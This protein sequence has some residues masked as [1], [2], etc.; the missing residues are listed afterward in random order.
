MGKTFDKAINDWSEKNNTVNKIKTGVNLH[1][2]LFTV[3][4]DDTRL[5]AY[6]GWFPFF[7]N[8]GIVGSLAVCTKRP[9][10]VED[11]AVMTWDQ[12]H[13]MADAGWEIMSHSVNHIAFQ[14]LTEEEARYEFAESKRVLQSHGFNPIN[15]GWCVSEEVGY[16]NER[17]CREYY[18]SARGYYNPVVNKDAV[19]EI[20]FNPYN[21][22]SAGERVDITTVEGMAWIKAQVD[23]AY[24]ENRWLIWTGHS[25]WA[26][27]E[28]AMLELIQYVQSKNIQIVTINEGLDL[29][30]NY[31]DA[32]NKFSVGEYGVRID[33][34]DGHALVARYRR[35]G[36]GIRASEGNREANNTFLGYLSGNTSVGTSNTH[37][38]SESGYLSKL[39]NSVAVGFKAMKET[40]SGYY[41]IAIG[42]NAGYKSSGNYNVY[43]GVNA[44][45]EN[46]GDGC[47]GIGDKALYKNTKDH[48]LEVKQLS[49]NA[50]PLL[51]GFLNTL[52]FVQG[53]PSTAI[54]DAEINNNTLHFY[55][56][57]ANNKLKVKLKYAD[58]TIKNGD[59]CDL[60]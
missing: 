53:S 28:T 54:A 23:I 49:S 1:K 52:E 20:A 24:N 21:L 32:G 14:T 30:G 29:K 34:A 39:Y 31:I 48:L 40:I 8:L 22:K 41:S 6:T 55:I 9:G 12:I 45:N 47:I 50:I 51:K 33:E 42:Y 57:E 44:G 37:C 38:G 36:V 56:D 10:T 13:E 5:T 60:T 3:T 25:H 7:T 43:I 58:V 35:T 27:Y 46:T 19:C 18:R 17:I 16:D 11:P 15:F 4:F 59:V 2:P 26:E